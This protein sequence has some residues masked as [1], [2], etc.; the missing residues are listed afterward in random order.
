MSQ[1]FTFRMLTHSL[2][3]SYITRLPNQS[4]DRC[5]S[6]SNAASIW[7]NVKE[8]QNYF[9]KTTSHGSEKNLVSSFLHPKSKSSQRWTYNPRSKS[10]MQKAF[11]THSPFH[12]MHLWMHYWVKN[13][14]YSTGICNHQFCWN[15]SLNKVRKSTFS[16]SSS[17]L[18]SNKPP[19]GN[20]NSPKSNYSLSRNVTGFLMTNFCRSHMATPNLSQRHGWPVQ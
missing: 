9:N 3:E 8:P 6:F 4:L 17:Q 15:L 20:L 16:E 12:P 10:L 5:L 7:K 13:G 11:P 14:N 19:A 18:A 1:T 2:P